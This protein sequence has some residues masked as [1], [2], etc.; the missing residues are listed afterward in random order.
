MAPIS[1]LNVGRM[2]A[3]LGDPELARATIEGAR[4]QLH[5]MGQRRPESYAFHRLGDVGLAVLPLMLPR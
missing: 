4:L 5:A 1:L 3:A 2:Q